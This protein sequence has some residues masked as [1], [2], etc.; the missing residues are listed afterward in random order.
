M[1][2]KPPRKKEKCKLLPQLPLPVIVQ[3]NGELY[4]F[5]GTFDG[6]SVVVDGA[7]DMRKLNVMGCF[8]KGSLSRSY[9]AFR[10]KDVPEITRK[11]QMSRR[12]KLCSGTSKD[13]RKVIVVPDSDSEHDNFFTDLKVE[14]RL[15][16]SNVGETLNLCLAEAFFLCNDVKC[17]DV[18]TADG[19]A[20]SGE[21]LW[22]LFCDSDKY[23][24]VN[25]VAY[26]HFR[27]KNWVVK[28][29]I[30][31]GGDFRELRF[32]NGRIL[33][34]FTVCSAL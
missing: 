33:I 7:D 32:E 25:Y 8:G 5:N 9:P 16:A 21:T 4:K 30:K 27:C 15:D 11:R 1:E 13:T 20:R 26:Y 12:D 3:E 34:M 31:F 18:Q 29:G 2:L 23:F 24:A 22:T 6:F 10:R 19:T 14:Y 17:L 28:P